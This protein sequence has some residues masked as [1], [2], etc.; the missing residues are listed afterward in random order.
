VKKLRAFNGDAIRELPV[1]DFVVA[2]QPYLPAETDMAVFRALAPEVQT[3]VEV[4]QDVVGLVR[5]ALADPVVEAGAFKTGAADVLDG[6]AEVF[7]TCEW[8]AGEIESALKGWGDAAGLKV[9]APVRLAISG[10]S[11]G[12]PLGTMLEVL[13]RERAVERIR[14]ARAKLG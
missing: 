2:A 12:L 9:Q 6:A 14:A 11:K 8:R 4:L 13:G 3:R 10:E 5:F 1:D 7:S